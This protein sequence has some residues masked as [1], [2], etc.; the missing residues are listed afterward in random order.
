MHLGR[1]LSEEAAG[2]AYLLAQGH[3]ACEILSTTLPDRPCTWIFIA[4]AVTEEYFGTRYRIV[5]FLEQYKAH[6][7]CPHELT[8]VGAEQSFLH[9]ML[10]KADVVKAGVT[11]D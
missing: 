1:E 4:D 3:V 7:V 6:E 8:L 10:P 11:G 9:W 2:S 5:S